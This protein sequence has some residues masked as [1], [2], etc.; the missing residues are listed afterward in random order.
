MLYSLCYPTLSVEDGAFI[1]AYRKK[2]DLSF[3]DVVSHHFTIAFGLSEIDSEVYINHVRQIAEH[4]KRIRF[5]CRYAMLGKDDFNDNYHVFLVPDEGFSE[6]ALLHDK[7][8][9]GPLEAYLRL[10]IPYIPHITIATI[11]DCNKVKMLCD[12]LNGIDLAITGS[13]DGITIGHYDGSFVHDL[14]TIKFAEYSP[15]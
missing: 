9:A 7:V 10:D 15:G 12:E 14:E 11:P 13:L 6:I 5:S 1:Q 8:Y 4:T 2:Y 3:V